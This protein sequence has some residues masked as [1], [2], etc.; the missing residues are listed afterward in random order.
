[1]RKALFAIALLS[2]P[3]MA[4]KAP[5]PA[6]PTRPTLSATPAMVMLAGFDRDGDTRVTRTEFESGIDRSFK[7]GDRDGD[8][9]MS[10]LELG[11]WSQMWLGNAFALPGLYDFDRDEDDKISS[12]EFRAEF[13]R[14]FDA[15][16]A[17]KDGALTRSELITLT[18]QRP[19]QGR[20]S[21]KAQPAP[22]SP[23]RR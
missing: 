16:D 5:P 22:A 12:A 18:M 9:T 23:P 7:S 13:T 15:L 10:L 17:D 3:A 20:K 11:P 14:R 6:E 19:E 2:A 1:M 21:S 8:G 4:K